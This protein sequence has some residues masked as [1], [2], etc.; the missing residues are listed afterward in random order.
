MASADF[1][2]PLSR[3][4]RSDSRSR[5][6]TR[7]PRVRRACVLRA[8][9]DLLLSPTSKYRASLSIASLPGVRS[10]ASGSCSSLPQFVVGFLQIP[11]RGGHPCLDVQFPSLGS[12]EDLHLRIRVMPGT[13]T[14]GRLATPFRPLLLQLIL[15]A[16]RQFRVLSSAESRRTR[17]A[18]RS[19]PWVGSCSRPGRR[20][21]RGPG[22][23]CSPART[24]R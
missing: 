5:R 1:S 3:R 10:L 2:L 8:A 22:R 21:R 16:P 4:H 18:R 15:V 12:V 24:P 23:R 6:E 14:K 9:P 19:C 7:S 11:P 17:Y 13:Q 20:G